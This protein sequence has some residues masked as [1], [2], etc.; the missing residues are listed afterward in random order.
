MFSCRPSQR[1]LLPLR[2]ASFHAAPRSVPRF[3]RH[4]LWLIP[5][6]GGLFLCFKP[7]TNDHFPSILSDPSIIPCPPAHN[8][9]TPTI[10]SPSEIHRSIPR[11]ILLFLRNRIWE[12]ILTAKRFVHLLFLF[13]PVVIC[14]PTL[15]LGKPEKRFKGDR[16]GAVWWYGLLVKQMAAAGPTFIKVRKGIF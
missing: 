7:S 8:V 12:P 6:A 11:R 5:V 14:S 2:R 4:P 3:S 15:L 10:F 1:L 9:I 13:I 16:W